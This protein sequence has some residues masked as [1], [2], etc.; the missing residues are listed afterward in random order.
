[1]LLIVIMLFFIVGDIF[2]PPAQALAITMGTLLIGALLVG[3]GMIFATEQ[4]AQEVSLHVEDNLSTNLLDEL[5]FAIDN[6]VNIVVDGVSSLWTDAYVELPNS[7]VQQFQYEAKQILDIEYNTVDLSHVFNHSGYA[8]VISGYNVKNV[9]IFNNREPFIAGISNPDI[10]PATVTIPLNPVTFRHLQVLNRREYRS[11]THLTIG[12]MDYTLRVTAIYNPNGTLFSSSAQLFNPFGSGSPIINFSNIDDLGWHG[13]GMF[14]S[15]AMYLIND[16]TVL[17]TRSNQIGF[18]GGHSIAQ[19]IFSTGAKNTF[20]ATR[21]QTPSHERTHNW[22]QHITNEAG[23]TGVLLP[24]NTGALTPDGLRDI[25]RIITEAVPGMDGWRR[26]ILRDPTMPPL[27]SLPEIPVYSDYNIP[28]PEPVVP[29]LPRPAPPQLLPRPPESWDLERIKE[30]FGEENIDWIEILG[31]GEYIVHLK[32][33]RVYRVFADGNIE[34][35][36]NPVG[37]LPTPAPTPTPTPEPSPSPAPPVVY[38]TPEPSPEPTPPP[39][40]GPGDGM[41][42]EPFPPWLDF[43]TPPAVERPV[44]L[45]V[46]TFPDIRP[47]PEPEPD[48]QPQPNPAPTP[49]PR[50]ITVLPPMPNPQP[51][52]QPTPDPSA[53]P[54]PSPHPIPP[55]HP[56]P[57]PAPNPA[58]NPAP[59]PTP[60]PDEDD[61]PV[62]PIITQPPAEPP[63]PPQQIFAMF[64]FCIPWD[65]YNFVRGMTANSVAPYFEFEPFP[66]LGRFGIDVVWEIDFEMFQMPVLIFRYLML[67]LAIW[68]LLGATKR[69]LWTGGG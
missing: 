29:V 65:V 56:N 9:P 13:I 12:G 68:G 36:Y 64:P 66:F 11:Y 39:D 41:E 58:P 34:L 6:V 20:P 31:G 15:L 42:Y 4:V 14:I 26:P 19:A 30:A 22:Q 38:P 35:I 48:L 67:A 53:S 37:T 51:N 24:Q 47:Q 17:I 18:S 69:F 5:W 3:I 50:P 28:Y 45:P 49:T 55:F 57:A 1:M 25:P 60:R 52:P 2:Q 33:G 54:T 59:T 10:K 46:P 40:L 23:H 21:I 32:N 8:Q 44:P 43:F 7:V 27:Q 63:R 61:E 62:P 16:A